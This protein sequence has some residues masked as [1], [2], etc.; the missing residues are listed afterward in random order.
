MG[1][2]LFGSF[3]CVPIGTKQELKLLFILQL[4]YP[5]A[6]FEKGFQM[7]G[8]FVLKTPAFFAKQGMK[9]FLYSLFF[10]GISF[11]S[12]DILA[13]DFTDGVQSYKNGQYQQALSSFEQGASR[14][15]P[16]S[17]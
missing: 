8:S 15:D 7:N 17:E 6:H 3:I 5:L 11:F 4:W 13:D 10:V 16:R 1:F 14:Q 2:P 12:G 9:T